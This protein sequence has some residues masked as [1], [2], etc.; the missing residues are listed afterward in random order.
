MMHIDEEEFK[1]LNAL[2]SNRRTRVMNNEYD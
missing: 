2:K 1:L